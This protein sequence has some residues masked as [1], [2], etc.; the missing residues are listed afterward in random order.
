MH[1]K[2]IRNDDDYWEEV[3]EYISKHTEVDFSHGICPDC[4]EKLYPEIV[5]K[6][7]GN[8]LK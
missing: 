5:G 8:E 4:M 1:C 7:S 2:K 6:N 3:V